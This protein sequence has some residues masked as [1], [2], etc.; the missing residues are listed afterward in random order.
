[1]TVRTAPKTQEEKMTELKSYV[2]TVGKENEILIKLI[3]LLLL[4]AAKGTSVIAKVNHMS[5]KPKPGHN[6][7]SLIKVADDWLEAT[8]CHQCHKDVTMA[9]SS[10]KVRSNDQGMHICVECWDKLDN[11]AQHDFGGLR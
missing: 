5:A 9:Y 1:M 2:R 6:S 7:D 11:Q 8:H 10:H 4:K 3:K